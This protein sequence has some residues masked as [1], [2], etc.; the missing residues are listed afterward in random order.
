MAERNK[1]DAWGEKVN[2][3]FR[4]QMR[5]A[6]EADAVPFGQERLTPREARERF[7]N[8]SDG[9]RQQFIADRGEEN[10]L[11]MLKG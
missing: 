1:H 8:M 10:V 6:N 4:E 11:D 2:T 5:K 9:E 7:V 3:A